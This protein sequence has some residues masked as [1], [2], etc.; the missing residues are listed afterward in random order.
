MKW[1]TIQF[2]YYAVLISVLPAAEQFW[3]WAHRLKLGWRWV[4]LSG[5]ILLGLPGIIQAWW[6]IDFKHEVSPQ[7]SEALAWLRKTAKSDEVILSPL[8]DKL[9][10]EQD[11]R[12]WQHE[13]DRGDMTS[14]KAWHREARDLLSSGT[15]VSPKSRPL[16]PISEPVSEARSSPTPPA[17]AE[18]LIMAQSKWKALVKEEAW[19]KQAVLKKKQ[20]LALARD[21][22]AL[23]SSQKDEADLKVEALKKN[24]A[25]AS[26]FAGIS[27]SGPLGEDLKKPEAHP[28]KEDL[29]EKTAL[30]VIN[31][32]EE[33]GIKDQEGLN[34]AEKEDKFEDKELN[35]D[36]ALSLTDHGVFNEPI[37]KK[38]ENLSRSN[39]DASL[40]EVLTRELSKREVLIQKEQKAKAEVLARTEELAQARKQ[41]QNKIRAR[42]RALVK[43]E[44][45][46]AAMSE[47]KPTKSRVTPEAVEADGEKPGSPRESKS[48]RWLDSP[49]V[50]ALTFRNT[51]LE[52]TIS[53]QIMGFTVQER[54]RRM[55]YFY[56]KADILEAVKF[57]RE[58]NITYVILPKGTSWPFNPDGIPLR[59]V[60]E[61]KDL[62]IYKFIPRGAW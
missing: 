55:R 50:A 18:S 28:V 31:E 13:R 49:L 46:T 32:E 2:F 33:S 1:N 26:G 15:I 8:P 59:K 54:A 16:A 37:E 29:K 21:A 14:M 23:K 47:P 42:K 17:K 44:E 24:I 22:L 36:S 27:V 12:Q 51:Y 20:A 58:E 34:E 53:G 5:F 10:A 56:Q 62:A 38:E 57:L 7:T 19:A 9:V 41:W 60:Y 25:E 45:I 30:E 43:L 39:R 52:G 35:E 40:A 3:I 4:L 6:V 61:N 48:P 11:Y